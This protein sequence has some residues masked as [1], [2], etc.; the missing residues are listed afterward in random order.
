MPKI[1]LH[2]IRGKGRPRFYETADD[3]AVACD[4]YFTKCFEAEMGPTVT[5]LALHLG[6]SRKEQLYQQKRDAEYIWVVDRARL[7]VEHG[8]EQLLRSGVNP[9]GA[10][11]ALKNMQWSDKQEVEMSGSM[12]VKELS[13][14]ERVAKLKSLVET[15][16][17]RLADNTI[18]VEVEEDWM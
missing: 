8:Y 3:L 18:E 2:K 10:I 9:A 12:D 6:Y 7:M 17:R 5:G 15:A 4:E 13:E 1:E 16:R 11:F 14:G